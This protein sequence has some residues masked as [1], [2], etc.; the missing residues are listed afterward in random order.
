MKQIALILLFSM[1]LIT[2][3]NAGSSVNTIAGN[4][5]PTVENFYILETLTVYNPTHNQCD[6]SPLITASNARIDT[7]KLGKQQLRWMALSRNLLK[8]WNGVFNYGDTVNIYAGDPQIDGSW[9][10]QDNL[11]KRYKDRGDLLFD[12]RVRTLGKWKNVKISKAS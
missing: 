3:P 1:V 9:I 7:L 12:S 5:T 11:N 4:V 2:A 8:R 10:I 6:R